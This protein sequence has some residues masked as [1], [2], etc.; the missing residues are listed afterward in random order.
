MFHWQ[1]DAKLN[2]YRENTGCSTSISSDRDKHR[3]QG[4]RATQFVSPYLNFKSAAGGDAIEQN[5]QHGLDL[6]ATIESNA[7]TSVTL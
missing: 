1:Y 5:F 4:N 3:I 2:C 6:L 7:G